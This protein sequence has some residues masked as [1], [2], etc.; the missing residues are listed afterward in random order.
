MYQIGQYII[1]GNTGVC[2]VEELVEKPPLGLY[3]VL[4]PLY[5]S[6]II[7]T[8]AEHPKIFMR[9]V[10]SRDEAEALIKQIPQIVAQPDRTKNLQELREHYRTAACSHNCIDLIRLTMSIHAKKKEQEQLGRRFGQVDERF[11][12][13]AENI[14][15]GEFAVALGI[16][17]DE[18]HSYI[19][20]QLESLRAVQA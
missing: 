2:K 9:P 8:P 14:L 6:G 15:F 12:K 5:E 1:Y 19:S 4:K 11:M 13:Q 16:P 3:Y 10:I 17:K 20:R 7:Y 18:V